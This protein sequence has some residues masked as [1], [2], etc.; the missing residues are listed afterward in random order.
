MAP[1]APAPAPNTA[2]PSNNTRFF[3]SQIGGKSVINYS[4]TDRPGRLMAWDVYYFFKF[5]W[6]I[7]YVLWP[8]CPADSAELSELSLTPG[9]AFCVAVHVVLCML[10]L[11]LLVALPV[12]AVFPVWTAATAVALFM[13]LNKGLCL[14]LNGE[15]VEYRSD[16]QYAPAL[17]EHAHEQWIFINGVSVGWVWGGCG[18]ASGKC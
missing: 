5:S 1:P 9:N 8:L 15:G 13:L 4:Y 11:A 3:G 7:P 12:L 16:P 14:L 17:P 6:A 18:L 10:Q 2:S